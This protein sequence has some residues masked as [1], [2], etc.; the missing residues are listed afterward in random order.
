MSPVKSTAPTAYGVS[1]M[2]DGCRPA[3]PPSARAQR[4]RGPDE[5]DAGA[6]RVEVH[7]PVARRRT[8]SMSSAGEELRAPRAVLRRRRSSHAAAKAGRLG[9]AA[10]GPTPASRAPAPA[11]RTSPAASA[12]PPWPPN[13]PRVKVAALPRKSARRCRRAPGRRCAARPVAARR[14]RA[15]RPAGTSTGSHSGTGAPSTVHRR[16]GAGRRRPWSACVNRSA[17][18]SS[19][20][21]QAGR[22]LRVAERPVA[23]P[24]AT[25]RPSAR[26]AARRRASSPTRPGQSC[27]VVSMPP[28]Q[29]PSIR[30]VGSRDVGER[31]RAV[32]GGARTP[33]SATRRAQQ[34]E[35]GLDAVQRVASSASPSSRERLVAVGAGAITLASSGS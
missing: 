19:G 6:R 30:G 24:E 11:R 33:W 25:G 5:P 26:S 2:L 4:G 14:R 18:P 29:R 22:A 9:A 34:P 20:A 13:R 10:T 31:G 21:L 27:T 12:R 32:R 35:V 16:R 23:E 8:S 1:W 15:S 3:S 28:A 7:L 17:G